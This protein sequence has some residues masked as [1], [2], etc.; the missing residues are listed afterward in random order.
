VTAEQSLTFQSYNQ[1][2]LN[3]VLGLVDLNSFNRLS[4]SELVDEKKNGAL[5]VVAFRDH[6]NNT[7]A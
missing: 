1:E 7:N 2:K 4:E 5:T 6:T 3:I